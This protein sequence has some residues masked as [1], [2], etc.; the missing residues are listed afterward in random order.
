MC[1]CIDITSELSYPELTKLSLFLLTFHSKYELSHLISNKIRHHWQA[2][3][4]RGK[5]LAKKKNEWNR[6]KENQYFT[7]NNLCL[8]MLF[9]Y[10]NG[11]HYVENLKI[12]VSSNP[13]VENTLEKET[14]R[15]VHILLL[16]LL[17]SSLFFSCFFLG[18]FLVNKQTTELCSMY[19]IKRHKRNNIHS[20]TH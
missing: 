5:K 8:C 12:Y 7:T 1:V 11:R 18:V 17:S 19:E 10:L 2:L 14:H 9:V 4:S 13:T 20:L 15:Y 3:I 6:E 16:L